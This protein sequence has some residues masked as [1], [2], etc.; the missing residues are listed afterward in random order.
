MAKLTSAKRDKLPSREFGLPES[1]GYPMP[2]R[3]HA[4]NAKARASEEE[5]KG[6]LS[7]SEKVRIDTKADRV[8]GGSSLKKGM[9][10]GK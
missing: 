9:V 7:G 6:N 1:K 3:A 10:K 5:K 8:L 4:A 2:D